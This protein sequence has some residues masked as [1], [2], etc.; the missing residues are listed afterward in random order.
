MTSVNFKLWGGGGTVEQG[1]GFGGGGGFSSGT[2]AVT[3][4]QVFKDSCWRRW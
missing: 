2:L 3:S 4:G 1:S